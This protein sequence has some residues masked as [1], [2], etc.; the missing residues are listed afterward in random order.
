[1][2]IPLHVNP[3]EFLLET[4]N[5]D[6]ARDREVAQTRLDELQT[7]WSTSPRA[8]D[9]TIAVSDVEQKTNGTLELESAEKKPSP[10]SLVLTLLHRSFIKSYRDVVAYGIRFAMYTGKLSVN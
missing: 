6:F 4:V 3:A 7:T 5:V 9:L 8:A 2:E 10:P 1:M